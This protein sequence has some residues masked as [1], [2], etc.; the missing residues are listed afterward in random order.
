MWVIGVVVVGGGGATEVCTATDELTAAG[1]S[2][3][4]CGRGAGADG[5]GGVSPGTHFTSSTL[6]K[7][8]NLCSPLTYYLPALG[9]Q[10]CSKTAADITH[11]PLCPSDLPA[12]LPGGGGGGDGGGCTASC[13]L[14]QRHALQTLYPPDVPLAYLPVCSPQPRTS[15][16]SHWAAVALAH[17]I[18]PTCLPSCLQDIFYVN[19]GAWH[20]K[21]NADWA[22]FV[23]ALEALGKDY[24]VN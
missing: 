6:S 24:Q 13:P 18:L 11:N 1:G 12:R 2:G 23:P 15:S 16:T 8:G 10:P 3:G 14:H 7:V 9:Q 4:R 19:F 21:N 20:R 5:G 22:T 17:S